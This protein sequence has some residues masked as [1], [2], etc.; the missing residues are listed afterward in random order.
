[1]NNNGI[2]IKINEDTPI[3][4]SIKNNYTD[5]N[6]YFYSTDV[7]IK[8]W[9]EN[10]GKEVEWEGYGKR[11]VSNVSIHGDYIYIETIKPKLGV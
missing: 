8:T 10:I 3:I 4:F 2:I 11:I 7:L 6:Y 5:K 1:M 9:E